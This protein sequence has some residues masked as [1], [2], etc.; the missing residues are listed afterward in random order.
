[1]ETYKIIT[2]D[3]LKWNGKYYK[4]GIGEISENSVKKEL[5]QRRFNDLRKRHREYLEKWKNL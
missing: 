2:S 1:M 3:I 5:H 4:E